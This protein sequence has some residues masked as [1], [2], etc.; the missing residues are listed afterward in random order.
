MKSKLTVLIAAILVLNSLSLVA[1]VPRIINYQGKVTEIDGVAVIGPRD[2][3]FRIY[4]DPSAGSLLWNESHT[5]VSIING[6]FDVQ[7]GSISAIN[8]DFSEEYWLEIEVDGEIL[9]PRQK[10]SSVPY[11]FRAIWADSIE[12]AS[13]ISHIDSITFIDSIGYIDSIGWVG[14]TLWA[15]SAHWAGYV[16]WDSIDGIPGDIGG[17]DADWQLDGDDMYS[18]PS[19]NVGIG[20]S[21]P[22]ATAKLE[23][24]SSTSGFLLPRMT[25]TERDAISAPAEAL[26]IFNTTSSCLQINSHDGWFDIWCFNSEPTILG[27]PSDLAICEGLTAE[28]YVT[29]EGEDLTY[30]WQENT[31]TG[32]I[33]LP[34]GS[35]YSGIETPTMSFTPVTYPMDGF[36]YRCIVSGSSGPDAIS[37]TAVLTV[38]TESTNPI[39]AEANVTTICATESA[40]LW[41]EGGSLGTSASWKWYSGSCGGTYVATGD[42][43]EVWPTS[44]TTYYVRA[45]GICN[46]TICRSITINVPSTRPIGVQYYT[47]PGIYEFIVPEGA[48]TLSVAAV[49][50]GGGGCGHLGGMGGDPDAVPG[51]SGGVSSFDTLISAY[52][53]E[54]GGR[55]YDPAALG[56]GF[57]APFGFHGGDGG[58]LY[59]GG[60]GGA[61]TFSADGGDGGTGSPV[62]GVDGADGG[63]SGGAGRPGS[64][65]RGGSG[66][67]I[68]LTG[69]PNTGE[70]GQ[71]SIGGNYGGGGG[72]SSVNA[73]GGGG[74]AGGGLAWIND[75]EVAPGDTFTV[76]V[77]DGGNHGA[78][79]AADGQHGA[80]RVIWEYI[81][82]PEANYPSNAD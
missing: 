80:V 81:C 25:Q 53:G 77:G 52:G 6:L 74:G 44:N 62:D 34:T 59:G 19:G 10:L 8:L 29:A 31:G 71:Y 11:A 9:E 66:G 7:L 1:E 68:Y 21:T 46:T 54:G 41:V 70:A 45:E 78:E 57:D 69:L 61:G 51:D 39:S 73:G 14:H 76:I 49:G 15:D 72:G 40:I 38:Y 82:S 35:I 67:G 56:G 42:T 20:I 13:S 48:V 50:G 24:A 75:V 60:G 28:F 5:A 79:Y 4:D 18:M 22:D 12:G 55:Q 26:L 33:D 23:V 3:T 37:E 17:T 64:Y 27:H 36:Q 32:W 2:M 47:T 43:I 16:H 58:T 65:G 30:Q 63:D